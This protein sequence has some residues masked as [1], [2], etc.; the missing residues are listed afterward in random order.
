MSGRLC[1]YNQQQHSKL[2]AQFVF[3]VS[4]FRFNTRMKTHAPLPDCCIN[5]T[6]I[7]F[8]PSCQDMQMQFVDILDPPFSK[9]ACSIMSCLVVGNFVAIKC[10]VTKFCRLALGS[11]VIMPRRVYFLVS[12][13]NDK[14][15]VLWPM[16]QGRK[17]DV[18]F[19]VMQT[20]VLLVN[21]ALFLPQPDAVW[22]ETHCF[23]HV[24]LYVCPETLLTRY[25]AEYLTHF[26]QT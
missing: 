14:K 25:L 1:C 13:N 23:C 16:F 22:S 7:Q 24:H 20:G 17:C 5:N 12:C 10:V 18:N 15:L 2:L 21:S 3:K 19:E 11:P 4:A 6:L 9:I 26:H 8:V